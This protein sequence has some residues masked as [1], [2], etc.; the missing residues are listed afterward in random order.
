MS[1]GKY[2]ARATLRREDTAVRSD[3]ESYQHA[4][5]RLTA[6]NQQLQE[7]LASQQA[8]SRQEIRVLKAQ[9]DEGLSP[10]LI[11]LRKE[12]ERQRERAAQAEA[13]RAETRKKQDRLLAF[14]TKLLHDLTGCTGL[15]ATEATLKALGGAPDGMIADPSTGVSG[16]PGSVKV[17]TLQRV[18]GY[19]SSAKVIEHL[20]ALCESAG[21]R[22]PKAKAEARRAQ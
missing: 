3:I 20:N 17:A 5:K 8:I 14:I 1:R 9:L 22:A 15:E 4:V 2:A 13:S 21:Q 18:R 19:R 11:T 10:E 6:E 16:D 7:G 12:L